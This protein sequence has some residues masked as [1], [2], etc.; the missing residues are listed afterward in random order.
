MGF[1][2]VGVQGLGFSRKGWFLKAVA[3]AASGVTVRV[4][5]AFTELSCWGWKV[6][7]SF[8]GSSRFL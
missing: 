1:R 2:G 8:K 6:S 5:L 3:R 4:R 7:L